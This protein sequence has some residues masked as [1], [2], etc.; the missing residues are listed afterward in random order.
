M[1]SLFGLFPKKESY[2]KARDFIMAHPSFSHS[3]YLRL[4]IK[5]YGK[6][7]DAKKFAELLVWMFD[8]IE[9]KKV[10]I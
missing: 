5:K 3:E 10:V 4:F 2:E 1:N 9:N 6:K 7:L 8:S